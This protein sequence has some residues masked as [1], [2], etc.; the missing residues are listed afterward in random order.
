MSI[1]FLS[2]MVAVIFMMG[3]ITGVI[4]GALQYGG[5][6]EFVCPPFIEVGT[7]IT[8]YFA[9]LPPELTKYDSEFAEACGLEWQAPVRIE[10][11]ERG[12]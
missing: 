2:L 9:E 1:S 5:E 12:A 11:P 8:V 7:G 3:I 4:V 10:P 6:H